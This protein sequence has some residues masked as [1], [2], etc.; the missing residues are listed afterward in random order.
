MEDARITLTPVTA[1][2]IYLEQECTLK[3]GKAELELYDAK[4][5][6]KIATTEFSIAKSGTQAGVKTQSNDKFLVRSLS[7]NTFSRASG[8]DII[9]VRITP[10]GQEAAS[11]S[12]WMWQMRDQLK[13]KPL[14]SIVLPGTHD[15][16]TYDLNTSTLCSTDSNA[17]AFA[18]APKFGIAFAKAQ[19]LTMK[20]QLDRG[21]RYFD[22]RLCYQS[23]D[24]YPSHSLVSNHPFSKD[25]TQLEEYL[26]SNPHEIIILDLQH[27]YGYNEER[28]KSL[29]DNIQAKFNGR[30][31][32]YEKYKPSSLVSDIWHLDNLAESSPNLIVVLPDTEV[33]NKVS[34][35]PQYSFVWPRSTIQSPWPNV[36]DIGLLL[37]KSSINLQS[38]DTN[39]F[40]ANQLLLTPDTNYILKNPSYSLASMAYRDLSSIYLRT[41]QS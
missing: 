35:E 8:T 14:S 21:I 24:S 26:K 31:I 36:Q 15:S 3:S 25:L 5:N 16:L 20:E 41:T 22:I 7:A 13:D 4:S 12:S 34:K 33:V 32:S 40:F 18:K 6:V 17:S 30:L 10:S 9:M 23:G 2:N 28:L 29:L 37:N 11:Y 19:Y 39:N 38:R 1:S 27:I